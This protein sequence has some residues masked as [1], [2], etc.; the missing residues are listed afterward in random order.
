M[1]PSSEVS[2]EIPLG[3][4]GSMVEVLDLNSD[5][6]G[7]IMVRGFSSWDLFLTDMR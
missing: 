4:L 6:V 7:D 1:N 3:V 5:G 2:F